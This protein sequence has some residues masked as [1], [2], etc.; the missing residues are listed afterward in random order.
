MV[1]GVAE[2]L[3]CSAEQADSSKAPSKARPSWIDFINATS[4]LES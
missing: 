4:L 1:I 2:L 3:V